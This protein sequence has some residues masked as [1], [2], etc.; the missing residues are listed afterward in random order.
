MHKFE[1]ANDLF[2]IYLKS[3][4]QY[5]LIYIQILIFDSKWTINYA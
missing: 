3:T 1:Y 4:I 2:C 5:L